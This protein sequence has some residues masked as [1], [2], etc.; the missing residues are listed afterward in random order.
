M[1]TTRKVWTTSALLFTADFPS[2]PSLYPII[3]FNW[4]QSSSLNLNS[5]VSSIGELLVL[6]MYVVIGEQHSQNSSKIHYL[7]AEIW[8]VFLK[9]TPHHPNDHQEFPAFCFLALRF[10]SADFSTN[11]CANILQTPVNIDFPR[12]KNRQE[13]SNVKHSFHTYVWIFQFNPNIQIPS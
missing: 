3:L 5:S 12:L 9:E 13:H 7:I 11:L 8:K 4:F 6:R 10:D 2:S 1:W